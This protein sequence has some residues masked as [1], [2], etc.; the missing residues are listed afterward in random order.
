MKSR[1]RAYLFVPLV[2]SQ[3]GID[4]PRP[5][6]RYENVLCGKNGVSKG[7]HLGGRYREKSA[8]CLGRSQGSVRVHAPL[9][10]IRV[11]VEAHQGENSVERQ[12]V[13]LIGPFEEL[14]ANPIMMRRASMSA[15]LLQTVRWLLTKQALK[16]DWT[17]EP[18]QW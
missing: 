1:P 12:W 17:R 9:E 16:E 15:E 5:S 10:G 6:L 14:F 8:R 18:V 13:S 11:P 3:I 7:L 2:K 4:L